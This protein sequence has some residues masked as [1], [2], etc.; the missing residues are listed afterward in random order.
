MDNGWRE[1][2]VVMDILLA[3]HNRWRRLG[4]D[5]IRGQGSI[6]PASDQHGRE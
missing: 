2:E 4:D 5:T 6:H 1:V 3:S